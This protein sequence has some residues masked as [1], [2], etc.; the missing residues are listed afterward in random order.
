MG[1]V[2]DVMNG[3]LVPAMSGW[4]VLILAAATFVLSRLVRRLRRWA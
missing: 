4:Q 2:T 1:A 3:E